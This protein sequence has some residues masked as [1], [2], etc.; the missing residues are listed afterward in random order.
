M[1]NLVPAFIINQFFQGN[2]NGRFQAATLFMDVS[3]FTATSNKFVRQSIASGEAMADV[4]QSIF[5]PLV[6]AVYGHGGFITGFAGDAFT[7]VFPVTAAAAGEKIH[8][9]SSAQPHWRALAAGLAMQRQMQEEPLRQTA[10]G[11]FLFAIKIGLG[12][13][14]VEWGI[15]GAEESASYQAGSPTHA[16]YFRGPAIDA[17]SFSERLAGE[18]ELVISGAFRDLIGDRVSVT[19]VI[20]GYWRVTAVHTDL[21]L[22]HLATPSLIDPQIVAYFVPQAILQQQVRGEY[23]HVYTLFLQL[24]KEES[25]EELNGFVRHVFHLIAQYGGYLN[26]IH[27][28]DKGCNLLLFWGMPTSHENDAER[29][30]NFAL[31]LREDTAVSFRAGVSYHL[32]Y[33][34]FVGSSTLRQEYSCYGQGVNL[35]ARLMAAAP[36]GAIWL[37]DG[38]ARQALPRFRLVRQGMLAFKGF[39]EPLPVFVLA[40]R[41]PVLRAR[42]HGGMVARQRE[43][44]MLAKWI[45][46]QGNGRSPGIAHI[47]GEAGIGKSRLVSEFRQGLRQSNLSRTDTWRWLTCQA[48]EILRQSLN[49][50]RQMLRAYFQQNSLKGLTENLAL[51]TAIFHDL[52]QQ[53]PDSPLREGLAQLQSFLQG[54]VELPV[55][56]PLYEKSS[57]DSRFSNTI[58][59]CKLLLLAESMRQPVILHVEDIDWLDLD[60]WQLL[61]QIATEAQDYPFALIFTGRQEALPKNTLI[62]EKTTLKIGLTPLNRAGLAELVVTLLRR[63]PSPELVDLL[64]ERSDGNPFF[65]QQILLYMQENGFF[66]QPG[67]LEIQKHLIPADVRAVLIARLD[68]LSPKARD[69]VQQAAILGREFDMHVLAQMQPE[70]HDLETHVLV[71]EHAAIWERIGQVRYVFRHALLR[72]AAYDMQLQTR[73]QELHLAAA[74]ALEAVYGDDLSSHYAILTYHYGQAAQWEKEWQ[75]AMLAGTQAASLFANQEAEQ[76]LKRALDLTPHNDQ[77]TQFKLLLALEDVHNIQG[78]RDAQKA[79][80]ERLFALTEKLNDRQKTAVVYNRQARY[81]NFTSNYPLAESAAAMCLELATD[82]LTLAEG[83]LHQGRAYWRQGQYARAKPMIV[84]A[85]LRYQKLEDTEGLANAFNEAGIVAQYLSQHDESLACYREA[86]AIFDATGNRFRKARI[87][88]NLGNLYYITGRYSQSIAHYQEAASIWERQGFQQGMGISYLNMG[89][90][91]RDS[92]E[93]EQAQLFLERA[94]PMS[95]AVQETALESAILLN[96]MLLHHQIGAQETAVSQG[97]LVIPLLQSI[98]ASHFTAMAHTWFGHALTELAQYEEARNHYQ[99]AI[100]LHQ[101]MGQTGMILEPEAGLA[102]I[103]LVERDMTALRKF[104][105]AIWQATQNKPELPDIHERV[106]VYLTGYRCLEAISDDRAIGL[107]NQGYALLQQL[108]GYFNEP[109]QRQQFIHGIDAHRALLDTWQKEIRIQEL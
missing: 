36:W 44:A 68:S 7:A 32:M 9:P 93:Y 89:V 59:A 103:S 27:F 16:Y 72:D 71:G 82:P 19:A 4:M 75:F 35:A 58:L 80:L 78:K 8:T 1:R 94:L 85:A 87:L 39:S 62:S 56:D 65:A 5:D 22:P 10:W 76:Y 48:D 11:D 17:C 50:F 46:P 26:T 30:L 102:R 33:A 97:R 14:E 34:G 51:F 43:M 86:L 91:L 2:A 45:Q 57:G 66:A 23:R 41:K 15:I 37:D 67:E 98:R 107:L 29:V 70:N 74:T 6:E 90:A 81:A 96:L 73:R 99:Q 84:E 40:G 13:G 109:Q 95:Q 55:N 54:L 20:D 101:E 52:L 83:Y 88:T 108:A 25:V 49:P 77:E 63:A 60:S 12:Y 92:G 53:I 42:H 79:D 24:P 61:E 64:A 47:Y 31:H 100:H 38:A 106:R 105:E 21:P 28:G 3:G 104:G 18:N 69:L